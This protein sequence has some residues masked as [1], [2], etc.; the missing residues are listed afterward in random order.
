LLEALNTELKGR[1]S[2]VQAKEE[3]IKQVQEKMSAEITKLRSELQ[4]KKVTLASRERDAWRSNR[5]W[6]MWKQGLGG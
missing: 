6:K 1:D 2:L 3:E 5:R 4:E